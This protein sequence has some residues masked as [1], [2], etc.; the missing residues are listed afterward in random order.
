MAFFVQQ[1]VDVPAFYLAENGAGDLGFLGLVLGPGLGSYPPEL[2]LADAFNNDDLQGS[3]VF[4]ALSPPV[5]NTN[6]AE[7]FVRSIH[8]LV[9]PSRG[10][11]WLKDP[12]NI[13]ADTAP[14]M[15][16]SSNGNDTGALKTGLLAPLTR[17]LSLQI[18]NFMTLKLNGTVLELGDTSGPQ[19]AFAGPSAPK[20]SVVTSGFIDFAGG[21]R[22]CVRFNMF[23]ERLSLNEKL[24][25]GFQF[26]FPN[27]DGTQPTLAEWLPLASGSE[28]NA[29][30]ML[31]FT[32][33][34]DT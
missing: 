24:N 6:G 33:S 14:S 7:A 21:L 30:D 13:N 28:P 26:L 19:I 22:G 1:F 34:I 5:S 8:N 12:L 15:T 16:F 27:K 9:Q 31:G 18:Q 20:A 25:W 4:S 2:S 17:S 32:I 3:F 11:I 23:L 10:F 29:K